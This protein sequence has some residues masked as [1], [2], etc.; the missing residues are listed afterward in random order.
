MCKYRTAH[1]GLVRGRRAHWQGFRS[2][3]EQG[4]FYYQAS[5][6]TIRP[7]NDT[8]ESNKQQ[9]GDDVVVE[10]GIA[11]ESCRMQRM[12][13]DL[14]KILTL[15]ST[16]YGQSVQWTV[17]LLKPEKRMR[18][19]GKCMEMEKGL[20]EIRMGRMNSFSKTSYNGAT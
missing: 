18:V 1:S 13:T 6:I 16:S 12:Q 20:K 11:F 4:Y 17:H 5:F 3:S 14:I 7:S 8:L 10:R 19:G 9:S 2:G 15:E